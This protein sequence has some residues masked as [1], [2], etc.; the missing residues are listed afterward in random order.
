MSRIVEHLGIVINIILADGSKAPLQL[1]VQ[2][3]KAGHCERLRTPSHP[4]PQLAAGGNCEQLCQVG[5]SPRLQSH[6]GI[7]GMYRDKCGADGWLPLSCPWV[8][9]RRA[10]GGKANAL[11]LQ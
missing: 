3:V 11:G 9:G 10:A 1:R 5:S 4:D 7:A 2:L 8:R 6:D